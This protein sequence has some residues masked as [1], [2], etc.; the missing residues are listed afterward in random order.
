MS[1]DYTQQM[2]D[3]LTPTRRY[4]LSTEHTR[5][6]VERLRPVKKNK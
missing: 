3:S 2:I 6:F 1:K 5:K 4:P